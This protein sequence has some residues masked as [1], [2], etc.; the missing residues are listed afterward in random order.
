MQPYGASSAAT[1][2][3]HRGHDAVDDAAS[4]SYHGEHDKQPHTTRHL[5]KVIAECTLAAGLLR[6]LQDAAG[7]PGHFARTTRRGL[8]LA[9]R[10][11]LSRLAN[12]HDRFRC[13]T[14][15]RRCR[16]RFLDLD[17]FVFK[18][19]DVARRWRGIRWWRLHRLGLNW[20]RC[21]GRRG[22]AAEQ[23][24]AVI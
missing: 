2:L 1:A 8:G 16:G 9:R 7:R 24:I 21:L 5:A 17:H 4:N 13:P 6:V 20:L 3:L 23:V 11:V 14:S 10:W 12:F 15:R 18:L 19:D 22:F